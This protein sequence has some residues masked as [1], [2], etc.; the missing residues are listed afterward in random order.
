MESALIA[1]LLASSGVTALAGSAVR[2]NVRGQ[3]DNPPCVVVTT[4]S[5]SPVYHTGGQSDLAEALV[6]MDC[7]G[8]T[9][10]E[11]TTLAQAVKDAIPKQKFYRNSIAFGGVFQISERHSFEGDNP[12]ARLH[13]VSIDFRVWH[14][15]P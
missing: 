13:R 9:A 6:Q 5:R 11:A 10:L 7:W 12:S 8:K 1:Q 15:D 2:P 14:S 3:N 4:V